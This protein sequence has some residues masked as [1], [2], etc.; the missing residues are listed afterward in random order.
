MVVCLLTTVF[1]VT[2]EINTDSAKS[3]QKSSGQQ[4]GEKGQDKS[5]QDGEAEG[6]LPA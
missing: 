4:Q 5:K 2:I 1:Q 3:Q 6:P